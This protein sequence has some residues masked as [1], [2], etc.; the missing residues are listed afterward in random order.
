MFGK[1]Q[2]EERERLATVSAT[3]AGHGSQAAPTVGE[4][5]RSIANDDNEVTRNVAAIG[6]DV[7]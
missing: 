4:E 7:R 1:N 3:T 5:I 2:K 6:E